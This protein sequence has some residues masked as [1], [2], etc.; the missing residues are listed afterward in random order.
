MS[1]DSQQTSQSEEVD[2]GQLFKMIGNAFNNFIK[3]FVSFF[4]G[5]YGLVLI[6]LIHFHKR[7][8]WYALSLL[9]GLSIGYVMD[10]KSDK[11]YGANMFIETN[12]NSARQVY[13]NI[14]NLHE[15]TETDNDSIKLADILGISVSEAASL[16][17]FYIEPDLDENDIV[18]M[19]S[20]FYT[21]L[22]SISRL[23]MNYDRYK[24][25]LTPYNYS[26]HKIGVA[27]TNKDI[28]KK[29]EKRFALQ[30][31]NNQYLSDL[32]EANTEN[33]DEREKSLSKQVIKTDSLVNEYLKIR[34]NESEKEPIP[35]AGTNLY[36]GGSQS[37]SVLVDE[38]KVID[39][40]LV[41]ENQKRSINTERALKKNV[42]NV[43]AMFPETGYDIK[44]WSDKYR[45]LLPI[46]LFSLTLMAFFLL[47]LSKYLEAESKK[48]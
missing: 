20:S 24:K 39:K 5:L 14:N 26:I 27:S 10:S 40:I 8:V 2:L 42:V 48:L 33:L 22:D 44:T 6:V 17:G 47:G 4:K 9:V 25:S 12:F 13:E 37:E 15:L 1:K 16:K 35:G 28:Y 19:Y 23:E 21:K 45:Y 46:A 11:L 43:L 36:M 7:R 31:A 32:L 29:I 41:L 38:S 30:L 18:E 3:F 34:I